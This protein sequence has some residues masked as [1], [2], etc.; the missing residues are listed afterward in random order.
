LWVCASIVKLGTV[1]GLMRLRNRFRVHA[2]IRVNSL[3]DIF[4]IEREENFW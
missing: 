4:F 1:E 2:I 3:W